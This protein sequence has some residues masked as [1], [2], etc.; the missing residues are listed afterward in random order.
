MAK[1]GK[2]LRASSKG[3][4][5]AAASAQNPLYVLSRAAPSRRERNKPV[6]WT[7]VEDKCLIKLVK[8]YG[9]K[10]WKRISKEIEQT[11]KV[12]RSGVQ[13]QHRWTKSLDPDLKKGKWKKQEDQVILTTV[14]ETGI[15]SVRWSNIAKELPGRIGKQVRERYINYLDPELVHTK[16]TVKEDERLLELHA[17]YGNRWKSIADLIQGRSENMVK[18]RWHHIKPRGNSSGRTMNKVGVRKIDANVELFRVSEQAE[19]MMRIAEGYRVLATGTVNISNA[20]AEVMKDDSFKGMLSRV[21][22]MNRLDTMAAK[23]APTLAL[24]SVICGAMKTD[25]CETFDVAA[26]E[27]T[28]PILSAYMKNAQAVFSTND[29]T[30][31]VTKSAG[32]VSSTAAATKRT[33]PRR[34]SSARSGAVDL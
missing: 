26:K 2:S 29:S 1:M 3:K 32:N 13:C 27:S 4:K 24:G 6:K 10:S 21:A 7:E 33:L 25:D 28:Y 15:S 14:L 17:L 19:V 9:L 22:I 23:C 11:T 5:K 8:K 12:A 20:I 16:F 30:F 31:K 34:R 18:N